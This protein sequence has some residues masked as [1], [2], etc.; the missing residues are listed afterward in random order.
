[1][2][3]DCVCLSVCPASVRGQRD[4][5]ALPRL[6]CRWGSA[7][8]LSG[9]SSLCPP[10]ESPETSPRACSRSRTRGLLTVPSPGP[11]RGGGSP[12][13]PPAPL[14]GGSDPCLRGESPP[15]A[16]LLSPGA[17]RGAGAPRPP[18][19]RA[20]GAGHPAGPRPGGVYRPHLLPGGVHRPHLPRRPPT[21]RGAGGGSP[22]PFQPAG[23]PR[24]LFSGVPPAHLPRAPPAGLSWAVPEP[25][26]SW[27]SFPRLVSPR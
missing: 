3:S 23:P 21:G 24:P 12:G 20:S 22:C 4:R 9:F 7:R 13:A 14:P 26:P 1:M 11:S 6:G 2:L 10:P 5:P 17:A 15:R 27:G 8:V 25:L 16:R 18:T 19:H